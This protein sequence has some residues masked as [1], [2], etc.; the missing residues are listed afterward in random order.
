MYKKTTPQQKLFGV[1]T[2]LSPSLRVG[3]GDDRKY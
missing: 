1:D 2:H 3:L